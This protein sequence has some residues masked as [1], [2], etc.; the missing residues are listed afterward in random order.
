M[1][2]DMKTQHKFQ[3][4]ADI[5]HRQIQ[6]DVWLVG[7]K[8][9]SI[10]TICREYNISLN[11]A[12]RAYS[13]LER[14]TLIES[15]PRSGYFVLPNHRNQISIPTISQ[16]TE[17]M[18]QEIESKLINKVFDTIND[19]NITRLSLGVPD[20][21]LLPVAKLNKTMMQAIRKLPGSGTRYEEIQGNLN[22]RRNIARWSFTWGGNLSADDIV[23]TAGAMDAIA[24]CMMTLTQPGDTIALESPVFFG[25]LQLAK[26]LG[27]NVLELPTHPTNGID[28]AA[29]EN[30][31]SQ[32]KACLLVSN[33]NNPLGSCMPEN[34]KKKVVELLN[35]H[36]IPLIE[37]DLYGDVYFTSKRPLPCKSFDRTGSVLWCGS[38]SKTLAPGYRIGWVAPGKYKSQIIRWKLIH[39][40]STTTLTQEAIAL[41]LENGRYE[42]HL[43]KMR[44][45]LY[46]N[47]LQFIRVIS[48]HFPEGTRISHPQ[49]GFVLW[50]E[51]P[52]P[53][54]TN[55]LYER[56]IK[57]KISIAPGRM[58]TLQPQFH[59][60]MRL[61]YGLPWTDYLERQLALLGT[62][63]KSLLK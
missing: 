26:S 6:N 47:S 14:R 58:F 12:T 18:V 10:R 4:I 27:L 46:T 20:E 59:N 43:R 51:C 55:E 28:I 39:S 52:K 56:A 40:V 48:Q 1:S 16:P 32:I 2:T 21:A 23:I 60:C 3:T 31:L 38:V 62:L 49:G 41:F 15:R 61:S 63:A 34:H 11:T 44:N 57:H 42:N 5:I 53:I 19:D 13:E 25:I 33:F 7:E 37:D 24:C 17:L 22:L 50:I 45:T 35:K 54:D 30:N 9:P 29:L 36:N 8:L